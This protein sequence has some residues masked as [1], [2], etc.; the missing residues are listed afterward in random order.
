MDEE[1][2]ENSNNLAEQIDHIS[3]ERE[4]AMGGKNE[5]SSSPTV[6]NGVHQWSS[7]AR[8][9]QDPEDG[10]DP[11]LPVS[12]STPSQTQRDE[13]AANKKR[14]YDYCT[15]DS[16]EKKKRKENGNE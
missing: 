8:T 2:N 1:D 12:P 14:S 9:N 4:M 16:P 7:E 5:E 13:L 3:L 6:M 10:S 11:M 15:T